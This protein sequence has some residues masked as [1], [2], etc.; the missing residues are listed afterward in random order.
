MFGLILIGLAAFC[1]SAGSYLLSL[2]IKPEMLSNASLQE[3]FKFDYLLLGLVFNFTGSF[4]WAYG[5]SK[6]N[7]YAL[8]WNSYLLM[9]VA[10]GVII[11]YI[12]AK[13]K[14]AISQYIGIG[15]AAFAIYM[16]SKS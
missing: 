12:L 13:D 4:F 1:V 16:I 11:S 15:L 14:L 7:S 9:L 10:F 3:I 8:A 6:L 5:R 2:G